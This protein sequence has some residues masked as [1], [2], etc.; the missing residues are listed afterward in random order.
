[1]RVVLIGRF[2]DLQAV[3]A[4]PRPHCVLRPPQTELGHAVQKHVVELAAKETQKR[5]QTERRSGLF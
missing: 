2:Q 4:D 5:W 1:M 3:D